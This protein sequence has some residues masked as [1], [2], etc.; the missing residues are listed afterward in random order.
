MA[1]D[2][3]AIVGLAVL[4]WITWFALDE[5]AQATPAEAEPTEPRDVIIITVDTLR[6]DRVG[7]YH[8]GKSLTPRID[9]WA[10]RG[11]TF[12]EATVPFPRTTPALVS[13]N[14]GLWPHHHGSREVWQK[15]KHGT[16]LAQVLKKQGYTTLGYS[17]NT[18]AG[19]PQGLDAG[20]D[21]FKSRKKMDT[22]WTHE[23]TD[24]V[25]KDV[26]KADPDKPLFLWVHYI[27]PHWQYTTPDVW[28]K[29]PKA[30]VCRRFMRAQKKGRR[31]LSELFQNENGMSERMYDECVTMYENV[32]SYTDHYIGAL[33]DGIEE[34]RTLDGALV[35]ITAD[36]GENLGEDD[37]WFQH[38]PSV[39]DA[40]M[41]VPMIMAGPGIPVGRRDPGVARIE[42]VM[43]TVLEVLDVP[44][45][46]VP[47]MDGAD[48]SWR[49]DPNA[50]QPDG[51][52]PVAFIESGSALRARMSNF[53]FSGRS[54]KNHCI[55]GER[56]S[57]CRK[58]LRGD[59]ELFDHA[60]DPAKQTPL[61]PE[62][63]TDIDLDAY[64]ELMQATQQ[65]QPEAARE[66]AARTPRFKLVEKPQLDGTYRR[67]LFDLRSE[68]GEERDVSDEYPDEVE[69]LGDLLDRWTS[70]QE[71]FEP[72]ERSDEEEN[73]LRSLGYIQ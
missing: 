18:A 70:D 14:T 45:S 29:K 40:S 50:E 56:Y 67:M 20:F 60:D 64:A 69:R 32:I 10:A 39:H 49:W 15:K 12:M 2:T 38:G 58:T 57:V 51:A 22:G 52:L 27:N 23:V 62:V 63:D 34:R 72:S 48:L 1:V 33:L 24:I 9:E 6:A 53:L 36:H 44:E 73:E 25:L 21:K 4:A 7:P 3:I 42:D 59:W 43:P 47:K 17:T 68:E 55:N 54:D 5:K 71:L 65:W 37:L 8:E 19:P 26:D 28:K 41:R 11:T 66:R 31:S 30:S 61:D 16:T 46:R 13:L 35:I